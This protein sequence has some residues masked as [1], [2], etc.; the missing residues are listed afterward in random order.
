MRVLMLLVISSWG[1]S[2]YRGC[3]EM[4]KSGYKSSS[5]TYSYSAQNNN[6]QDATLRMDYLEKT[7][8][9]FRDISIPSKILDIMSTMPSVVIEVR[10]AIESLKVF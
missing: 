6:S 10:Q 5:S 7:G 8:D 3:P 9:Y 4:P 2:V 1:F